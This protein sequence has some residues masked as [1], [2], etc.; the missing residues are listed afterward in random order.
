MTGPLVASHARLLRAAT[1]SWLALVSALIVIDHVRLSQW[2]QLHRVSVEPAEVAQLKQD[3]S[4]LEAALAAQQLRPTPLSQAVYAAA[5]QSQDDRLERIE[6]SL[7]DRVAPTDLTPLAAR[8]TRLE[9]EVWRLR[10]PSPP[11][12]QLLAHRPAEHAAPI[13]RK[14]PDATLPFTLLGVEMRGGE[15]FLALAPLGAKALSQVRVLRA[16]EADGEWRLVALNE[17]TA[18]FEV[19]GHLQHVPVP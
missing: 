13:A 14:A 11:R 8:L 5:E 3:L 9:G 2:I 18:T 7:A 10:H 6:Q 15:R 1:V 19:A 4:Q 16:G 17:N 12:I